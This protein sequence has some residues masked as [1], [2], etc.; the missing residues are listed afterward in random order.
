MTAAT[1][2]RQGLWLAVAAWAAR[3][4]SARAEVVAPAAS[5]VA[6]ALINAARRC[7][8]VITA[9]RIR[10]VAAKLGERRWSA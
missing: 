5:N 6:S 3:W 2:R 8:A 9:V 7:A 1:G 10:V 4:W